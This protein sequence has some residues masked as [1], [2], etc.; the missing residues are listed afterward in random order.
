M[1][2]YKDSNYV[3]SPVVHL[4]FGRIDVQKLTLTVE[5]RAFVLP[6]LTLTVIGS[7]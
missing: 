1:K 5:L 6:L 2:V 7:I 3:V 4:H